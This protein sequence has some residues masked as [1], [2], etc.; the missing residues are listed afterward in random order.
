MMDMVKTAVSREPLQNF[1][2]FVKRTSL[3][4]GHCVI[5]VCAALPLTTFELMLRKGARCRRPARTD[6]RAGAEPEDAS[7]RQDNHVLQ[8]RQRQ[9]GAPTLADLWCAG[10]AIWSR[11]QQVW[12][13][14]PMTKV[15]GWRC[16][17]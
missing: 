3:Q 10:A 8:D 13:A 2:K 6:G 11:L 16:I 5:P 14:G 17:R 15:R 7:R 1:R 9:I 4:R 12:M